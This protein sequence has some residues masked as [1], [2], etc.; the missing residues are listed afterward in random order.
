MGWS[1]TNARK[2]LA[3]WAEQED[4]VN[5]PEIRSCLVAFLTELVSS[6]AGAEIADSNDEPSRK[7]LLL[8]GDRGV[9]TL[10]VSNDK[11][12]SEISGS[13]AAFNDAQN[14]TEATLVCSIHDG[15]VRC[16]WRFV[17]GDPHRHVV[18]INYELQ[19]DTDLERLKGIA[20]P[21]NPGA[22]MLAEALG[23][24]G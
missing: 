11:S 3:R 18:N 23:W 12:K 19:A 20:S 4:I 14:N 5:I 10:S 13:V 17:W 8:I 1:E 21:L 9:L 6:G 2:V 15:S 7:V 22:L 16:E 24:P